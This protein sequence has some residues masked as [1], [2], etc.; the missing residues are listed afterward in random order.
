MSAAVSRCLSCRPVLAGPLIDNVDQI[1]DALRRRLPADVLA[2]VTAAKAASSVASLGGGGGGGRGR[3][4]CCVVLGPESGPADGRVPDDAD[5]LLDG[6][7]ST[8]RHHAGQPASPVVPP[9]PA[10][11]AGGHRPAG[12]ARG[13]RHRHRDASSAGRPWSGRSSPRPDSTPSR[14]WRIRRTRDRCKSSTKPKR[15][16]WHGFRC[17]RSSSTPANR[18]MVTRHTPLAAGGGPAFLLTRCWFGDSLA[19]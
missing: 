5:L 19:R 3:P 18:L 9:S 4:L 8:L 1:P 17:G 14:S 6:A 11:R 10:T 7:A 12:S 13:N 15:P 2:M 16:S